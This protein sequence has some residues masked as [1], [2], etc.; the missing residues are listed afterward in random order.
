MTG[1]RGPL[2]SLDARG[3]L[4]RAFTLARRLS[5]PRWLLRGRP[6]NP[7]TPAQVHWRTMWQLAASL[8]H[9]LSPADKIDWENAATP[10]HMTGFAYYMSQALRPNPGIYL[11]LAGGVM[12]GAIDMDG[13]QVEGLVDP[14]NNGQ[15]ARKGYVDSEISAAV[16]PKG[17]RVTR[18]TP[19]VIGTGAYTP[20]SYENAPW[21]T[22][23]SWNL[24]AAPTALICRTAGYYV[25]TTAVTF[26]A[27]VTG[28][29]VILLYLNAADAIAM[30]AW[31]TPQ[32]GPA[33]IHVATIY[34]LVVNDY[35][36]TLVYQ[37]S[38]GN[39]DVLAAPKYSPAFTFH[40]IG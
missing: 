20:V 7:R 6:A 33:A 23:D 4:T 39:L 18:V 38:G 17:T 28:E 13:H 34:H 1:L 24:L 31:D 11:P 26:A 37:T 35:L 16:A 15:A 36:Q 12:S 14:T 5:G 8:W 3:R 21:D 9:E 30:V 32:S 40:R 10:R 29:R 27:N 22:D 19:Q 2:L 25:I